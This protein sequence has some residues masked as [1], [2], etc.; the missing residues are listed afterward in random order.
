MGLDAMDTKDFCQKHGIRFIE[1]G[2]G[3]LY[4][5]ASAAHDFVD[6]CRKEECRILGV[7]GF[8]ITRGETRPIDS[9]VADFSEIDSPSQSCDEALVFLN[10]DE[11]REA[12]H[13]NFTIAFD[14]EGG[15][16]ELGA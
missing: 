8:R 2:E 11:T 6:S 12:S 10:C 1:R 13:F 5:E 15:N 7:E 3:S 9:L 4:V 16:N 14:Y